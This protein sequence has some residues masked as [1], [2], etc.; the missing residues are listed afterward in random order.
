MKVKD[1]VNSE[2]I[3]N[4]IIEMFTDVHE[5]RIL[6]I[7]NAV[8]GIIMSA[9]L[10][11]HLIGQ[12]LAAVKGTITKH[13]VKQV[14][15]LLSNIKFNCWLYF[16]TWVPQVVGVRKHIIVAMDW[17]NF[18]KDK[19]STIAIYLVTSHGRATPLIW[20]THSQDDLKNNQNRFE[21]EILEHLKKTLPADVGVTVLA[22][23][24]FG[25]VEF[26]AVFR[27]TR[28]LSVKRDIRYAYYLSKL[29]I[30]QFTPIPHFMPL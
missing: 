1:V 24:G 27:S 11:V 3:Y 6:S 20:K 12:G 4:Y 29:F 5:K 19:H 21:N 16:Y 18:D 9:S 14:D 7:S 25:Y 23:R 17:T 28:A 10:A 30:R 13:G 8:I 26:Y 22:D 2:K 15:R